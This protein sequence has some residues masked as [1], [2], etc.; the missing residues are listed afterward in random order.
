MEEV[1]KTEMQDE[2]VLCPSEIT[3]FTAW[4]RWKDFKGRSC[5]KEYW[6]FSLS[7]LVLSLGIVLFSLP[8]MLFTNPVLLLLFGIPFCLAVVAIV[9]VSIYLPIPLIVRRL[10][11]IGLSGYWILLIYFVNYTLTALYHFCD[12]PGGQIIY[13]IWCLAYWFVLGFKD[14]EKGTNKFGDNPKWEKVAPATDC[15]RNVQ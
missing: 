2:T 8:M 4:K 14:S 1:E 13:W 11:D 6:F 10:H 5:R 9:L 7:L 3:L 12:V 15:D